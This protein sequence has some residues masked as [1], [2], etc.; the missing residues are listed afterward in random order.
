MSDRRLRLSYD[1][2][3]AIRAGAPSDRGTCPSVE[4][5]VGLVLREG[6]EDARLTLL[7]HVM[8]CPFCGAEFA[9]LRTSER[10][11]RAEPQAE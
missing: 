4:A 7:D 11:S 1:R 10:A 2:L 6:P 8:G 9:M 3:L 5:L